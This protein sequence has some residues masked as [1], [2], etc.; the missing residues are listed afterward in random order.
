MQTVRSPGWFVIMRDFIL[1]QIQ[2]AV[3]AL[4]LPGQQEHMTNVHRGVKR[5]LHLLIAN[6]Y[7]HAELPN[8]LEK[9]YQAMLTT[10][11]ELSHAPEEPVEEELAHWVVNGKTLCGDLPLL[12]IKAALNIDGITCER[13]LNRIPT[14]GKPEQR[15]SSPSPV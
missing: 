11:R 3:Q 4:D 9:H 13:C 5:A 7:K 14:P 15:R 6:A 8:P 1:P 12:P 10:V 2:A